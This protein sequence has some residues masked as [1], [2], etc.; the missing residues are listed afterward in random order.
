V[1]KIRDWYLFIFGTC[2]V[3]LIL[4]IIIF[5]FNHKSLT[6]DICQG[7]LENPTPKTAELFPRRRR[8]R[9]SSD[10][11]RLALEELHLWAK[12]EGRQIICSAFFFFFFWASWHGLKNILGTSS[13]QWYI[14]FWKFRVFFGATANAKVQPLFI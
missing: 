3:F 6:Y 1:V 8:R 5:Y 13:A 10:D 7:M 11:R 4:N 12:T 2:Y 9:Q 14:W